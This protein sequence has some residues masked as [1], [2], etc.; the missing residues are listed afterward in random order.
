MKIN[1][2][3][4]NWTTDELTY[5]YPWRFNLT[6]QFTQLDDCVINTVD[7]DAP[8]GF[9]WIS[10]MSKQAYT[11]GSKIT[12]NCEFEHFGAPLIVIA[13]NFDTDDRGVLRCGNY[14][15]IVLWEKGVNVWRIYRKNGENSW[16]KVMAVTFPVK[17][18]E[19][20][21]LSAE[22]TDIGIQM[23]VGELKFFLRVDD[24]YESFHL[25]LTACEG[26]N[27]FYGMTIE[28]L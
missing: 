3:R 18:G 17:E 5:A 19:K 9:E 7:P 12:V 21:T 25:G 15:E 6:P 1:F 22:V 10:L 14:F 13:E 16:K 23:E 26:I 2:S 27:R 4:G 8:G 24:M 28:Q 20:H 11:K